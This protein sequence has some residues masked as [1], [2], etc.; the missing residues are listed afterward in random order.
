MDLNEAELQSIVSDDDNMQKTM[1][2]IFAKLCIMYKYT[3]T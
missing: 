1:D 2:C 3:H